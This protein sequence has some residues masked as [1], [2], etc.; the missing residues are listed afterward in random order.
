MK[1]IFYFPV[2]FYLLVLLGTSF[3]AHLNLQW[4]AWLVIL[5]LILILGY[6]EKSNKNSTLVIA[7][8]TGF[9]L[10]IFSSDFSFH[11]MSRQV[12]FFGFYTLLFLFFSLFVKKFLRN[13]VRLPFFKIP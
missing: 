1:N 3:F 11:L 13:N 7:A 4:V 8:L 12:N 5:L 2:F 6:S 10:D 9:F